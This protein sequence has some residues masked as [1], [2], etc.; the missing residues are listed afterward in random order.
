MA[1]SSRRGPGVRPDR[2]QAAWTD[3]EP[4]TAPFRR[5][6]LLPLAVAARRRRDGL[7]RGRGPGS[8]RRAGFVSCPARAVVGADDPRRAPRRGRRRAVRAAHAH[9]ATG[10]TARVW[11]RV[12]DAR[13]E[14][15][16]PQGRPAGQPAEP[17]Q[18]RGAA[19]GRGGHRHRDHAAVRADQPAGPGV[20]HRRRPTG[21]VRRGIGPDRL[22][23]VGTRRDR[24]RPHRDRGGAARPRPGRRRRAPAQGRDGRP[25]TEPSTSTWAARPT[26]ARTTGR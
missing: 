6:P 8:G 13:M 12:P 20:R 18:R 7:L 21:A 4:M 26:P 2:R 22:L 9:P 15:W 10:W 16:T 24:R 17:G 14:A 19:A 23:P 5:F 11:A 1:G 25:R 3:G